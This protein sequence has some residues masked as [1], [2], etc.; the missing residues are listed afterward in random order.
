MNEEVNL[1]Q[2]PAH[3]I[4]RRL[5]EKKLKFKGNDSKK[6]LIEILV[7]GVS[8]LDAPKEKNPAPVIEDHIKP[9]A[10][11]LLPKN[12]ENTLRIRFPKLAWKLEDNVITFTAAIPGDR[13]VIPSCVNV[14]SNER[15][16]YNVAEE[17]CGGLK[18]HRP[19]IEPQNNVQA[20]RIDAENQAKAIEREKLRA[21]LEEEIRKELT[22]G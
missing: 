15:I 1:E 21:E 4:K 10:V 16:I 18:G 12:F 19:N 14:D 7:S 6:N 11:P 8:P 17:A 13:S 2:L 20:A 9:K 5:T 3:E 22:D